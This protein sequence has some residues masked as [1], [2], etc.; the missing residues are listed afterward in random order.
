MN[1]LDLKFSEEEFTSIEDLAG[2]NYSPE[3]IALYLQVDKKAFMQLWYDKES[4]V[5]VAYERGK[6]VSEFNINNKQKEL[7]NTGNITAAQIFLKEAERTEVN[8]IRNQCLF[9]I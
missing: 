8:N 6:L 3:K 1:L 4:T 7:A 2:C 5:R 9:G